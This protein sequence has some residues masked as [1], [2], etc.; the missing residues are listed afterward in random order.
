MVVELP[1]YIVI[2]KRWVLEVDYC[3]DNW[4]LGSARFLGNYEDIMIFLKYYLK[5]KYCFQL[6]SKFCNYENY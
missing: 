1:V 3:V 4:Y 5:Y 6:K 2:A